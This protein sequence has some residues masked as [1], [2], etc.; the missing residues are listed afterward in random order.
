M[1][2]KDKKI[3][4]EDKKQNFKLIWKDHTDN[5]FWEISWYRLLFSKKQKR[6]HDWDL[7]KL[8]F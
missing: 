8:V 7:E 1:E 6:Q 2:N 4:L 3:Q 5:Y